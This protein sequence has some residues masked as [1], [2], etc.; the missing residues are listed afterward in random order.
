MENPNR[1]SEDKEAEREM[2][3]ERDDPE[4]LQEARDFDEYKDD[5]RRGWGNR[6]NRSWR[7][8]EHALQRESWVCLLR[9][10]QFTKQ[11]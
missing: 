7:G 4:L 11:I 1:I 3:V 8:Q 9:L 2:K 10:V 5:H 6:M